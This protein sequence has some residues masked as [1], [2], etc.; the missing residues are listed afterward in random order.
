MN[1]GQLN[2]DNLDQWWPQ[3]GSEV[4]IST[5]LLVREKITGEAFRRGVLGLTI[6]A[7]LLYMRAAAE[8][9]DWDI[10]DAALHL[11]LAEKLEGYARQTELSI[12]GVIPREADVLEARKAVVAS[13]TM[14]AKHLGDDRGSGLDSVVAMNTLRE[15][16]I[17]SIQTVGSADAQ[18]VV[19]LIRYRQTNIAT[20]ALTK[21]LVHPAFYY[22]DL[23][24]STD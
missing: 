21:R 17:S 8:R 12:F 7:V 3:M 15:K 18:F 23:Y 16:V 19:D 11:S 24:G 20:K 6:T 22:L 10:D 14:V 1:A 2:A 5:Q 9:A 13:F 4:T